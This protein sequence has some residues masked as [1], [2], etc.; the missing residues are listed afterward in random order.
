M[1]VSTAFIF[2]QEL[3]RKIIG[4][5]S[6]LERRAT[7]ARIDSVQL[8]PIKLIIGK[9]RDDLAGL[10]LGPAHPS[11]GDGYSEPWSPPCFLSDISGWSLSL[12]GAPPR[13]QAT[14]RPAGAACWPMSPIPFS[15]MPD[16][17]DDGARRGRRRRAS[18][19]TYGVAVR[20]TPIATAPRCP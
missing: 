7:A 19:A 15:R 14:E 8:D 20:N 10:E 6:Y 11:R 13:R 4:K 18:S 9:D 2:V 16:R 3:S 1:D 5:G 12:V 17:G